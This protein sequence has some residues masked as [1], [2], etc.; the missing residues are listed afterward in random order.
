MPKVSVI[1]PTYNCAQYI[2]EAIESVLNQ[3]YK[4]FEII[5]VDDGST[6][7]TNEILRSYIEKKKIRYFYQENSGVS[8]ARNMGVRVSQGEY[9]SFLD[10]D[11]F[12]EVNHLQQ[13]LNAMWKYPTCS[14]AFSAIEIFGD[15]KDV[16]EKN[17]AFKYSVSRC[18]GAAFDKK[19][20]SI[21]LSNK[22]LLQD[23]LERGFP[24]RIQA[25]L[26]K[27]DFFFKYNL[28]FD[29]DIT[30][31]EESQFLTIAAYYT[32]FIYIDKVAVFIR[33]HRDDED[34]Y[35]GQKIIDSF[36][37]RVI[38]L[39]R[40]FHG[41]LKNKEKKALMKALWSFQVSIMEG[42]S[43][44]RGLYTKI[45]ESIKLF[46]RVP[47]YLSLKSIIKLLIMKN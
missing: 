11:D 30:Y 16:T 47:C 25:S 31:T 33:K 6:D 24:F 7:N 42:R 46:L 9:I 15:A 45:I 40:F 43:K 36:D 44:N 32:P 3:T 26:I 12:W 14:V 2:T 10:S 17:K 29:D 8:S 21:W 5:V 35:Y 28:F 20:N 19:D 13:L 4:D 27:K 22:N 18:L 41:K 37:S 23:L 34:A 1:I 38:K 39:K